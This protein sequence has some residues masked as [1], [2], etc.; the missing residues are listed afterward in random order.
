MNG[1][2]YGDVIVG[3]TGRDRPPAAAYVYFGGPGAD[4][5]ADLTLT[6]AATSD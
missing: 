2:G 6:G 1:D 5:I 3:A 4:A